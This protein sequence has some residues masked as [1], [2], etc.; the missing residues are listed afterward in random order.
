MA[1]REVCPYLGGGGGGG[2]CEGQS[3]KKNLRVSIS[4]RGQLSQQGIIGGYCR[5]LNDRDRE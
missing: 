3:E 5:T 4:F 2:G 1:V